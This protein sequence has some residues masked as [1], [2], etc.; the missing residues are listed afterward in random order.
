MKFIDVWFLIRYSKQLLN[1]QQTKIVPYCI[2]LMKS[3]TS[4]KGIT[5]RHKEKSSKYQNRYNIS[6]TNKSIL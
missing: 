3:C 5:T 4:T 1:K 6:Y 2:R